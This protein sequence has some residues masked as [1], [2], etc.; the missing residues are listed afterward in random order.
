MKPGVRGH[1]GGFSLLEALIALAVLAVGLLTLAT[2]TLKVA[3]S[4][5]VA[6]QRGEAVRLAQ[7]R[8]EL[9]RSYTQLSTAAGAVAWDDLAN[10]SDT[11]TATS[12]FSANTQFA[13]SWQVLGISSDPMRN[14]VVTVSWTDRGNETQSVS[15]ATVISKTDPS[16][17]G[18]LGFPLPANTTLKRPKNRNLNIPVPALDLGNGQSVTQ[19]QNNFAVV[20]SNESGYVVKTCAFVVSTAAD[21]AGCTSTS[22]YIIA[23]YISLGGSASFPSGLAINSA[24]LSGSTGVTCSVANAV[25]Q[26]TSAAISGYK[27]YLCVISVAS[28]GAPWSGT[29]RLAAPTLNT[30]STQY[31]VCRFQFPSA[32]GVSANQRNVQPYASVS[33]SLDS[34]NYLLTSASSCPTVSALATTQHQN[35]RSSNASR[36]TDC[37]AS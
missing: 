29:V 37:P 12:T 34:Q 26:T 2:L 33:E 18:S 14:A 22:A 17:I 3:R 23:G 10:G 1:H 36:A 24:L 16:D 4:E 31:L 9:M 7:E 35:C 32:N 5:D 8:I 6:R 21:L 11:I 30:G 15:L 28:A 25:D 27:Y 19:L 20:F 13:R